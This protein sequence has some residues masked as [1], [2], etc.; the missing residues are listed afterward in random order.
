MTYNKH[1]LP[2]RL[3]APPVPAPNQ[4]HAATW[5]RNWNIYAVAMQW[6]GPSRGMLTALADWINR[7]YPESKKPLSR[8]RVKQIIQS[9][10]FHTMHYSAAELGLPERSGSPAGMRK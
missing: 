8:Q 3:I 6:D 4:D 9:V 5:P 7:F 1:T 10:H 2:E